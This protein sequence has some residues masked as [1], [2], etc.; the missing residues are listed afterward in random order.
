LGITDDGVFGLQTSATLM[1]WQRNNGLKADGIA[2]PATLG[3]LYK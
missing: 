3:K 1:Q 2:G